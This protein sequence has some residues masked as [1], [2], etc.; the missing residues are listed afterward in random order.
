MW[1]TWKEEA[2][3]FCV[4]EASWVYMSSEGSQDYIDENH[5]LR[6]EDHD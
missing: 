4:L 5:P 3:N 1:C 6:Q 2:G